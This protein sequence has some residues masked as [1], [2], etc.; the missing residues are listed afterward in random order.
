VEENL[1]EAAEVSKQL[2]AT[3]AKNKAREEKP[4]IAM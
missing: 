2:E 1:F 4:L 3:N